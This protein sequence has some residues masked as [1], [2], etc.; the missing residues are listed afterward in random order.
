MKNKALHRLQFSGVAA[1]NFVS[2]Q[3]FPS[4]ILVSFSISSS[5]ISYIYSFIIFNLSRNT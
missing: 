5:H 3:C 1:S 2:I 4:P